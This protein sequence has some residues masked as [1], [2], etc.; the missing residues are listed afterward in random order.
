M[1]QQPSGVGVMRRRRRSSLQP[2]TLALAINAALLCL[3]APNAGAQENVSAS[4]MAGNER[5]GKKLPD[6]E[7][8]ETREEQHKP[9]ASVKVTKE[10]LEKQGAGS[11]ADVL[12]YQPLVSVPGVTAGTTNTTSAYDHPGSTNYNIRG[13]EG[14]R[15]GVDVDDVEMPEAVDRSATS[16]SGRASI[17]TFG[18]G[19]DFIDPEMY[20]EV[21]VDSGTTTSARPA[22]GHGREA[23]MGSYDVNRD[24][25]VTRAEY[26]SVRLQRF[27]AADTDHDGQVD[28]NDPLPKPR[29]AGS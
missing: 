23:F 21:Q 15:V 24:G 20:S 3:A 1:A 11:F 16:G 4:P 27:A 18:Q 22:G 8:K 14:N 12:K 13:V 19:R 2:L 9:G 29:N 17:G 10:E 26:D 25:V 6:I 28:A 7:V 5:P